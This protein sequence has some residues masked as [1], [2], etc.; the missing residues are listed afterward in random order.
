MR[1]E[2]RKCF[3]RHRLHRKPLVSGPGMHYGPCV[4]H[5]PWCMSGSLTRSSGENVPG[6][7]GACAI[8]NFAYLVRGPWWLGIYQMKEQH[9]DYMSVLEH[10]ILLRYLWHFDESFCP[11]VRTRRTIHAHKKPLSKK[12]IIMEIFF[13]NHRNILFFNKRYIFKYN[14]E[15]LG[16]WNLYLYTCNWVS[17]MYVQKRLSGFSWYISSAAS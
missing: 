15:V 14:I 9:L 17:H 2:C 4:T 10:N 11:P 3:L 5:V 6:I 13:D 12:G 8:H 16:L 1:R 7:P